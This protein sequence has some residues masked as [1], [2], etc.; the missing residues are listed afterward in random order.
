MNNVLIYIIFALLFLLFIQALVI[1]R[2]QRQIDYLNGELDKQLQPLE[3]I[4]PVEM[5]YERGD[6]NDRF[7]E[8]SAENQNDRRSTEF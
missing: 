8:I 6:W 5:W 2:Q 7:K 3:P 1:R 4:D